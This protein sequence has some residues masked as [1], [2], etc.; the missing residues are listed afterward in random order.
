M[1][2]TSGGLPPGSKRGVLAGAVEWSV[3][4]LCRWGD[5]SGCME[6]YGDDQYVPNPRNRVSFEA[7]AVGR[8]DDSVL[9]V[10]NIQQ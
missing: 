10:D 6:L 2:S 7:V 1:L 9:A 5:H 8:R 4:A 3:V